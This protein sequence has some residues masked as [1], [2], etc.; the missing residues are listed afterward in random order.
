MSFAS[1]QEVAPERHPAK[2]DLALIQAETKAEASR[3]QPSA[4][5]KKRQARNHAKNVNDDLIHG[6][7][8]ARIPELNNSGILLRALCACLPA[9]T[10]VADEGKILRGACAERSRSAQNGSLP[11]AIWPL[12]RPK[13][14]PKEVTCTPCRPISLPAA[15]ANIRLRT[16]IVSDRRSQER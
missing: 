5:R 7:L 4:V 9:L 1:G 11:R 13:R 8:A 15:R 16:T 3:M 10:L 12:F 14:T 2:D 6:A